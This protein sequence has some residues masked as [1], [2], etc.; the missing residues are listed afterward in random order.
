MEGC[1]VDDFERGVVEEEA[2][3]GETHVECVVGFG[4]RDEYRKGCGLFAG[5]LDCLGAG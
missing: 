5:E 4:L 2:T 1:V 3:V